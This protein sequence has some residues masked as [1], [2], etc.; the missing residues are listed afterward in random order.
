VEAGAGTFGAEAATR[1]GGTEIEVGKLPGIDPGFITG[2]AV[3]VTGTGLSDETETVVVTTAAGA[4][5][6]GTA[7]AAVGPFGFLAAGAP[8]PPSSLVTVLLT[9]VIAV[10]TGSD[11]LGSS[12][13]TGDEIV[14]I[15]GG[16][17]RAILLDTAAG[18][19]SAEEPNKSPSIAA[20]F[21]ATSIPLLTSSSLGDMSSSRSSL[22]SVYMSMRSSPKN[23]LAKKSLEVGRSPHSVVDMVN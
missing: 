22:E 12:F 15:S 5:L 10:S 8:C 14:S 6:T 4:G 3:D 11:W 13:A 9:D 16:S 21:M 1:G 7:G 2:G 23:S 17:M 19:N 20:A 18:M